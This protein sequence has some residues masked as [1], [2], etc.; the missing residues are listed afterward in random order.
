MRRVAR[1][2][3]N[4]MED[5]ANDME[6]GAAND[7]EDSGDPSL[8]AG[9]EDHATADMFMSEQERDVVDCLKSSSRDVISDALQRCHCDLQSYAEKSQEEFEAWKRE[10]RKHVCEEEPTQDSLIAL[11]ALFQSS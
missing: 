4:D 5:I 9:A 6:D 7:M 10:Q 8:E 3:A 1:G 11:G 2:A